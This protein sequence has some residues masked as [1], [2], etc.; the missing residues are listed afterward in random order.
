MAPGQVSPDK[1]KERWN[2]IRRNPE[3]ELALD[4]E[5]VA[6]YLKKPEHELVRERIQ[7]SLNQ[8]AIYRVKTKSFQNTTPRG[9]GDLV[10]CEG[11]EAFLVPAVEGALAFGTFIKDFESFG[12]DKEFI[13]AIRTDIENLIENWESGQFSGEP[14][15]DENKIRQSLPPNT[16]DQLRG[17]INIT[18]AAAMAC[19][20]LIHLLTL[21]LNPS[22]EEL[23][24][25]GFRQHL[26]DK[27][28]DDRMFSA[29]GKA[30]DF[31]VHAFQKGQ[32]STDEERIANSLSS[33][34]SRSGW[35]WTDRPGLPPM[36]FFSA[37]A[38]DAFAELDLYLIRKAEKRKDGKRVWETSGTD[39]Q[40]KL[41]AFYDAHKTNLE[42]YQLC[43]DM[44]RRWV[45]ATALSNISAKLGE[46]TEPDVVYFIDDE[47]KYK[48][49]ER[50]LQRVADLKNKPLVFY[51]N[52]YALQILLWSWADWDEDGKQ[53]DLEAKNKFNRAL[54]QIVYNY[55]RIPVVK[56]VLTKFSNQFYLPGKG[57]LV[58]EAEK[59]CTYLDAGFLPLLTRLL[60]LF[61][62]YGVGDRN[63]LEPVIRG[64]YVELLQSRNRADPEYSALWSGNE[65][66]V[67]STQRAIQ[68]LTFYFA[69]AQGKAL[70]VPGG[71][72]GAAANGDGVDRIVFRN[73]TG[74]PL[75]LVA[76]SEEEV[77]VP[78][79]PPPAPSPE[80]QSVPFTA[81]TLAEYSKQ[82]KIPM[83]AQPGTL[84]EAERQLQV[85][86]NT[87]GNDIIASIEARA[88]RDI[89]A[90]R[91]VL[92]GLGHIVAQPTLNGA[93][94]K[95]E[96]LLLTQQYEDLKSGRAQ[97]QAAG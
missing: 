12:K 44:T 24:T 20:V 81:K 3:C 14:Y 40:K 11:L 5:S 83:P 1:V 70:V 57:F 23:R 66:E 79:P 33:G 89:V 62:V 91:L 41:L 10:T 92:N 43:V 50:D 72:P 4:P 90:A 80:P 34:D 63:L 9:T 77:V 48:E 18:E 96:L 86:A 36:L 95:P 37:A 78:P 69:Y 15:S 51:N 88:V 82:C 85:E 30:I 53:R 13:K 22:E 65:I 64:L 56:E 26:G 31:V 45:R 6:E 58:P 94:R 60:V 68:A 42:L 61:V 29:L 8:L 67:F 21:K 74:Q 54:A 2:Q 71:A 35:S 28:N 17:R 84:L 49:Y 93:L 52:L 46:H 19:R 47:T 97:E 38:V 16:Q 39:D 75:F 7:E 25:S 27:L 73:K 87:L 59:K 32:G 55:D 76:V